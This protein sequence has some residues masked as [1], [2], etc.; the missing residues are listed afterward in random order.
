MVRLIQWLRGL[1]LRSKGARHFRA[2]CRGSS[3]QKCTAAQIFRLKSP[4]LPVS[5]TGG[6]PDKRD[7]PSRISRDGLHKRSSFKTETG[8]DFDIC[9]FEK[10]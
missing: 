6:A 4:G 9:T 2:V 8:N 7:K 10:I 1:E 5:D 3:K